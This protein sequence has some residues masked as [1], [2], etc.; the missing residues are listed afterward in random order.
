M[1]RRLL[2]FSALLLLAAAVQAA[3]LPPHRAH[4]GGI[5]VIP[6]GPADGPQPQATFGDSPVLVAP[7]EGQWHAVVGIPLSQPPGT[8]QLSVSDGNN[9][10]RS[11]PFEVGD[12]SYR[13]Q[14]LTVSKSFVNPDP[15]EIARIVAERDIIDAALNS[16][17]TSDTVVLQIPAPVSGR[18][19]SSFGLRRYFNDQPRSPHSG[20]DIAATTGTAIRLPADGSVSVTGDFFFNGKTV[21]V[22]HGH[23]FISL[24]C[25]LSTIAVEAGQ[26]LA[27]G[28]KIGEVGATGRVTGP[29]LHFA[30]YLNGNAVDP[31]LLL[32]ESP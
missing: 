20:M 27:A 23:G 21:I 25:H 12:Y 17:R 3:E 30:T 13:E 22:D 6:L 16:W 18:K 10:S 7:S 28:E 9:A 32:A 19:S 26:Q 8:A 24:Y 29:H 4:P 31:A 11:V 1:T 2:L 14:R 15:D 5:A